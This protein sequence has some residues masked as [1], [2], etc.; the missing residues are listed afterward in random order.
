MNRITQKFRDLKAGGAKGFV[1]YIGAGDPDLEATRKLAL[2]FDRIGVDVLELGM[3]LTRRQD[4]RDG[5]VGWHYLQKLEEARR[6][7][8]SEATLSTVLHDN[9]A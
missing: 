8:A 1:V 5:I 9:G 2:A 6:R 7:F 3:R 4:Q